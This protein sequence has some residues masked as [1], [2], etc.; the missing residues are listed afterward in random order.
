MASPACLI[1]DSSTKR[2]VKLALGF[3]CLTFLSF[4]IVFFLSEDAGLSQIALFLQNNLRLLDFSVVGI[5]FLYF[6]HQYRLSIFKRFMG[7]ACLAI[8]GF[9]LLTSS[10]LFWGSFIFAHNFMAFAFWYHYAPTRQ[11][12]RASLAYLGIFGH[13]H[14]IILTGMC[15]SLFA[16]AIDQRPTQDYGYSFYSVASELFPKNFNLDFSRNIVAILSFGQ[17]LHYLFWLRVIPE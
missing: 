4:R 8:L 6:S 10:G 12:K 7:C 14:V 16:I 15:D 1:D 9:F 17:G 2:R 3:F 5:S 11:E 13:I